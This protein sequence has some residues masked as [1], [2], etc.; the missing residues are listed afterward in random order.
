VN[1][2]KSTGK[3]A[4]NQAEKANELI[5]KLKLPECIEKT[6]ELNG[7]IV[8]RRVIKSARDLL[9]A[10]FM[11]A[12]TGMSLRMLAATTSAMGLVDMSDQAWQKK[13]YYAGLGF[14]AY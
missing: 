4:N 8:R 10:L 11:Y 13:L 2:S 1:E 12:I 3:I 7:A 6:A 5:K 14:H 9:V